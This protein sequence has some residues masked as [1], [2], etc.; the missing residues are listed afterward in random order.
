MQLRRSAML[1]GPTDIA[2]TFADYLS[3]DN[4]RAF[5]YEQ[6]TGETRQFIEEI[7]KVTGVPVSLISTDFSMRNVIDRRAW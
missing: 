3:K 5:R 2:L 4:K 6:L 7:E 1:N